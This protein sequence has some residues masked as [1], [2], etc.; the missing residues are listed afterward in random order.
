MNRRIAGDDR[1]MFYSK[2]AAGEISD[3]AATEARGC[4]GNREPRSHEDRHEDPQRLSFMQ[5]S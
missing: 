4:I 5:P 2:V 3:P 1:R